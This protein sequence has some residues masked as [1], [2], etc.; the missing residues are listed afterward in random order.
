MHTID[1]KYKE[2][3]NT[4]KKFSVEK[5][6]SKLKTTKSMFGYTFTYNMSDGFP[7]ISTP[8]F[9]WESVVNELIW[10]LNG[11]TNN[12]K[13]LDLGCENLIDH[14]YNRYYND[15][16]MT[17]SIDPMSKEEFIE[18]AKKDSD[19]GYNNLGPVYGKQWRTWQGWMP[20]QN[21]TPHT[22]G[23]LWFDQLGRLLHQLKIN[24]NSRQLIVN[25]WNVAELD[26]M[27][28]IP[29]TVYFQVSTRELTYE[30]RFK[31]YDKKFAWGRLR[32][33]IPT[34]SNFDTSNIP[35]R[36]ISLSWNSRCTEIYDDFPKNI[37]FYGLLLSLIGEI[38][39]MQ[40]E[41]LIGNL[42][43]L[44]LN[45]ENLQKHNNFEITPSTTSKLVI[46]IDKSVFK[47]SHPWD[48]RNLTSD[49]FKLTKSKTVVI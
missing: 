21:S 29:E 39:N 9:K 44:Y 48:F 30:E 15:C 18:Q 45:S 42:G 23:S 32:N 12:K 14:S 4:F 33:D 8:N 31:L 49:N 2:L 28:V 1:Q 24:P 17:A 20:M 6:D 47:S 3:I 7:L 16:M 11:E 10:A 13:L 19:F 40:P 41:S 25:S 26:E 27:V 38:V 46:N 36:S 22:M 37:V 35:T 5:K 34:Q 43:E